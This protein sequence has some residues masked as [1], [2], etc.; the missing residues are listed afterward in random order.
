MP[1]LKMLLDALLT[2]QPSVNVKRKKFFYIRDICHETKIKA[3]GQGN[4]TLYV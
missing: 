1:N 2:I 3:I 4:G